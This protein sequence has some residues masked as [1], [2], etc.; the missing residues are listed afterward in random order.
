MRVSVHRPGW[1]SPAPIEVRTGQLQVVPLGRG[2]EAEVQIETAA[3]VTLGASR[4]SPRISAAVTGGSVG[5]ILD[6]RG[7]PIV[8]PR[9][10][11]DRRA[12]IAG[13]RDAFQREPQPGGERVA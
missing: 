7:I 10:G 9:R 6:A 5:L 3:G 2:Q 8:L 12:V 13:W 4:R 11:D 1:P